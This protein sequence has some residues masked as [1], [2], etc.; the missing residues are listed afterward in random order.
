MS[1]PKTARL[2]STVFAIGGL[3][4][5]AVRAE[6]SQFG[7]V[8]TT[9]LLPKG[10]Q[11]IEQWATWRHEKIGGQFDQL[12]GRTEIEYGLSDRLQVALYANYAWAQ[13]Y[14]NGPLG[15]T[16]PSEQFSTAQPGPDD[17][18]RAAH[19]IGT[20]VEAI[21]R[22]L[23]PY[24]D[25]VGLALYI[26]PTSGAQFREVESK[27]ILQ[28]N[29]FDDQL[30]LAC[31]LTYA[32]EWRYLPD[33][34]G[35][36]SNWQEETDVNVNFAASYRFRQNWSAGFEFLNEREYNSYNFTQWTNSGYYFG[37]SIHFG[38]KRFFVTAVF[39]EQL[40]WAT[41]HGATIPGAVVGG[42]DFD[43]DFEKFRVR[44]KTGF[45]F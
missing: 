17:Q 33:Y 8:Y 37:P 30:I 2:F 14:H 19:Y 15:A 11:E 21:Y 35:I 25:P 44:I 4:V 27:V 7:F 10:Q 5:G 9:D 29:Y 18:F 3:I 43:N 38:G 13:A 42:R 20:S 28:K 6:E 12:E 45:Y 31:N 36:H 22:V 39:L 40:P 26:E 41:V 32:P 34:S 16:T 23:S 1:T 24:T